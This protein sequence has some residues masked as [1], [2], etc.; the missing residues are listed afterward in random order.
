MTAR[1]Q[2]NGRYWTPPAVRSGHHL[3]LAMADGT[4]LATLARLSESGTPDQAV[5]LRDDDAEAI[6]RLRRFAVDR[7]E[8]QA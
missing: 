2:P 4:V 1:G 6:E 3:P 5:D 8:P 7:A